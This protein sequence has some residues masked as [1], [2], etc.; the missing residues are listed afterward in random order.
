MTA[1]T[2]HTGC[3]VYD[4]DDRDNLDAAVHL[5]GDERKASMRV[6]ANCG[7]LPGR[8]GWVVWQGDLDGRSCPICFGRPMP[9]LADDL[10]E[11]QLDGRACIRCGAD[12]QRMQPVEAW[13]ERSAQLF[14]CDDVE[15]CAH[16]PEA[17]TN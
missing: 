11:A 9:K 4:W 12:N 7:V 16:R 2:Q 15:A 8:V 5:V 13:S 17:T 3:L 1:T 10:T 6:A 14:E